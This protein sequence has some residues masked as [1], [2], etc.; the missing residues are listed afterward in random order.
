M[1]NVNLDELKKLKSRNPQAALRGRKKFILDGLMNK[2]TIDLKTAKRMFR[3]ANDIP[4]LEPS[5][6]MFYYKGKYYYTTDGELTKPLESEIA[7]M[8]TPDHRIKLH[9]ICSD[10]VCPMPE[11]FHLENVKA[12]KV[13]ND[14]GAAQYMTKTSGIIITVNDI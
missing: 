2:N 10:R 8:L 11:P 14:I 5:G 6:N 1:K 12:Q 3:N 4:G 9:L 13:S 7:N